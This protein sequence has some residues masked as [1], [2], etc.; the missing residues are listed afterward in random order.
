MFA[1]GSKSNSSRCFL[2]LGALTAIFINDFPVLGA[3]KAF[4][5]TVIT[6]EL[7]LTKLFLQCLG[8]WCVV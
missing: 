1:Q 8:N 7:C 3:L 6:G 2:L 4:L 5:N